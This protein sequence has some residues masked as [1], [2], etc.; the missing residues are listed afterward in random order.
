M[1]ITTYSGLQTGIAEFLGREEDV[2]LIARI[3][4]LIIMAES[5]FNRKLMVRQM[6]Q[7]STA[8]TDPTLTEPEFIVLPSD[9]QAMR[10]IRNTSA[11]G[12]P[13]LEFLS[14]TQIDTFRANRADA[15]GSPLYFS[16]FG[17]E[18]ELAPTPDAA[19]SIEMI[20]RKN[21]P[22]L[23]ASNISNWL[24]LMAP[25][26]YMYGALLETAPYTEGDARLQTWGTLFQDAVNDLNQLSQTSQFNAG[27][28][29]VRSDSPAP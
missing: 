13:V 25:D 28:L 14:S 20:Y 24:L 15:P 17:T 10:R 27:P 6:E 1:T 12:R 19:Y 29:T 21:I 16:I 3:P 8:L 9:F 26:L 18:I 11:T 7:R 4:D 2:T 5:K 22:A 23:S